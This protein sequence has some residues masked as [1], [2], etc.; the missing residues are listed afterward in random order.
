MVGLGSMLVSSLD[1]PPVDEAEW[2][3][4]IRRV[5]GALVAKDADSGE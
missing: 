2:K 1:I 3:A 4:L 5:V